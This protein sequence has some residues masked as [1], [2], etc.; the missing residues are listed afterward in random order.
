MEI[1]PCPHCGGKAE[2]YTR[3]TGL[4]E[5]YSVRCKKKHCRGRTV[6]MVGLSISPS[7]IGIGGPIEHEKSRPQ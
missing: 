5:K 7:G 6:K 3:T 4:A 2:L 1:E